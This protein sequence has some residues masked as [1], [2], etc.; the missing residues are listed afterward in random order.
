MPYIA[1][2]YLVIYIVVGRK[3]IM[4]KDTEKKEDKGRSGNANKG[5]ASMDPERQRAIAS[6]GGKA[7]HERGTAHCFTSEE[8]REAGRKGGRNAHK[9][10][11]AHQFNSKT[12]SEAGR[13]GGSS[14]SASARTTT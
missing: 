2:I 7:A 12:G 13:K 9:K 5:F 11:T 8:A 10:G 3:Y 4:A 1:L 14:K 6:K